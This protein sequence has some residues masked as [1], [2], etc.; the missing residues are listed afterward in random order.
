MQITAQQMAPFVGQILEPLINH[1]N[2]V[3]SEGRRD[4]DGW[5]LRQWFIDG[6]GMGPYQMLVSAGPET[7]MQ[8]FRLSPF[9]KPNVEQSFP[10]LCSMEVPLKEFIEQFCTEPPPDDEG[11]GDDGEE[12]ENL[13]AGQ[14][15]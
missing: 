5:D 4:R 7:I 3:D 13:L 11:E 1:I 12:P 8:A 10:G 2:H 6:R 9:W 14:G 15:A